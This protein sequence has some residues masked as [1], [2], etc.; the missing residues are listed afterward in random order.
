V[1][2]AL[3]R[4]ATE[5][6]QSLAKTQGRITNLDV[7]I[8]SGVVGA[9]VRLVIIVDERDFRPKRILWANETGSTDEK[10]LRRAREKINAQLTK[11][12]G[13]IA[14]FY[15]KFITPMIPKH[16]YATLIIAVNGELPKKV[17][18]LD[19]GERREQ[20]AAMLRLLNNDPKAINLV[21]VAKIFGVSR[22]TI[23]RDLE[24]LGIKR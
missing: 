7:N 12:R 6:N 19:S 4:A 18:K 20:L 14:G 11:L 3:E 5:L 23:Y 16:T 24:E 21:R 15:L 2:K 22:D 9:I 1:R 10:A 13:E 8:Y 17:G